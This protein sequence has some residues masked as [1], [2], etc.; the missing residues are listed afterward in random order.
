[1]AIRRLVQALAV[2]MLGFS[3]LGA[4]TST[5]DA[6]LELDLNFDGASVQN[7]ERIRPRDR[8]R[9]FH[10]GMQSREN[11]R[12]EFTVDAG[13]NYDVWLDKGVSQHR[14]PD[15]EALGV[16]IT[17][18]QDVNVKDK[19][20]LNLFRHRDREA[21]NIGSQDHTRY[22]AFNF[23]LDAAYEVPS[24]WALHL[25][26]WQCCGG[27]PPFSIRSSP[28]RDR[29]GPVELTFNV[30]EITGGSGSR[31]AQQ[32]V[33]RMNVDRERWYNMVLKLNPEPHGARAKGN[34]SMWL[35][36]ARQ[37]S[38]DGQWGYEPGPNSSQ[39]N[40]IGEPIKPNMGIGLGVY[41]RRQKTTQ[42]IYF[43]NIRYGRTFEA[44]TR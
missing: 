6:S 39:A 4:G 42:I 8:A 36:G 32:I 21:I 17:A 3:V 13:T 30:T 19:I 25:Q 14:S 34:I 40:E 35:D 23:K 7:A 33:H 2:L 38:F 27:P 9:A 11:H 24:S 41:R 16:K 37:F 26:I 31:G 43:D 28:G 12:Y 18:D 10:F 15:D 22:I 44:V 1:M 20:L 29:K 5:P